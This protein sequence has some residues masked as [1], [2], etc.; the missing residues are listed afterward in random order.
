MR[1]MK[2]K[3][4][5]KTSFNVSFNNSFENVCKEGAH[6]PLPHSADYLRFP[7]IIV[8]LLV[9]LELHQFQL[10][11]NIW[12]CKWTHNEQAHNLTVPAQEICSF[13]CLEFIVLN[14]QSRD[15]SFLL[16]WCFQIWG[17]YS[18]MWCKARMHNNDKTTWP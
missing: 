14:I 17:P 8:L 16:L 4:S 5:L 6:V 13:M 11:W 7:Y 12:S 9:I 15:D 18:P 1:N 2:K 3:S 10:S